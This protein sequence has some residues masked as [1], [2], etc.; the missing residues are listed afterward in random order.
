MSSLDQFTEAF[1]QLKQQKPQ[2]TSASQR[3]Y[4][5]C[6]TRAIIMQL[7]AQ[8]RIAS[9]KYF[10]RFAALLG[11]QPACAATYKKPALITRAGRIATLETPRTYQS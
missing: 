11:L 5:D 4:V 8:A 2:T 3:N 10:I 6:V 1:A 9:A 7:P